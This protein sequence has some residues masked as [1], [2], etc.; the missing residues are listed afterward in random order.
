MKTVKA[1]PVWFHLQLPRTVRRPA[2]G[3]REGWDRH[4]PPRACPPAFYVAPSLDGSPVTSQGVTAVPDGSGGRGLG[5][6]TGTYVAAGA[7]QLLEWLE[8]R[9]PDEGEV[10][11]GLDHSHLAADVAAILVGEPVAECGP[12][13]ES[14]ARGVD[15]DEQFRATVVHEP[16]QLLEAGEL[17]VGEPRRFHAPT[18]L[19][20]PR[21]A[22]GTFP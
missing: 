11:D 19:A 2:A 13:V 4:P 6:G 7:D 3:S 12:R 17:L 16:R 1:S 18:M 9:P 20:D 8:H 5:A 15:E 22:V 14:V 10:R 21:S